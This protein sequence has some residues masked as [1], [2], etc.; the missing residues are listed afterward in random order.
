MIIYP[1]ERVTNLI[2]DLIQTKFGIIYHEDLVI[3]IYRFVES[4]ISVD[5]EVSEYGK[6]ISK[7]VTIY[8]SELQIHLYLRSIQLFK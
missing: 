8:N 7:S 4:G 6:W 2:A 3:H 1:E 5:F